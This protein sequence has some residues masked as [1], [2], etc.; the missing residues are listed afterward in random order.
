MLTCPLPVYGPLPL[1]LCYVALCTYNTEI[2]SCS[3]SVFFGVDP[4]CFLITLFW[5]FIVTPFTRDGVP[6]P[7]I[8]V[9]P[10]TLSHIKCIVIFVH[11][12]C[13]Y[14]EPCSSVCP[15][16]SRDYHTIWQWSSTI[17]PAICKP[18]IVC[19]IQF[20]GLPNSHQRSADKAMAAISWDAEGVL[21]VDYMLNHGWL[22]SWDSK[23]NQSRRICVR[24]I[25]NR[26]T[27]SPSQ[28]SNRW[29]L[30]S[31]K[32]DLNSSN[33]HIITSS[34]RWRGSSE[35]PILAMLWCYVMV[36]WKRY[37]DLV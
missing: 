1:P 25:H 27:I 34:S 21:L 36:L 10:I 12:F 30:P 26:R 24:E 17:F 37:R 22:I 16:T 2:P 4:A 15:N 18:W 8:T 5:S 32:A 6:S 14:F 11:C 7:Y 29:W 33:C 19:T 9:Y 3:S 28:D 20:L 31:R 35:I 23:K 13:V